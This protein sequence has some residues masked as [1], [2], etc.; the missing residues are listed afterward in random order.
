VAQSRCPGKSGGGL[1][2]LEVVMPNLILS[3]L[4]RYLS[5]AVNSLHGRMDAF[6][7]I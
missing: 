5:T 3:L 2:I 4:E 7:K 1:C 6:L